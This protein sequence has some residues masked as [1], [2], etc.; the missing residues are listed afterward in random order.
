[1]DTDWRDALLSFYPSQH[2][3]Q[4]A[5]RI[6]NPGRRINAL[7]RRTAEWASEGLRGSSVTMNSIP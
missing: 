1:M 7:G 6:G 2:Y 3:V 5:R 4:A